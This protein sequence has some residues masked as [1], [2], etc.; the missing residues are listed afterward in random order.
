M[1]GSPPGPSGGVEHVSATLDQMPRSSLPTAWPAGTVLGDRYRLTSTL[2]IGRSATVYRAEEVDTGGPVTVQIFHEVGRG[3]RARIQSFRRPT[4]SRVPRPGLPGAFVA[5]YECDL[6]NEGQLFLVTEVVEGTS[7]A[8]LL[9]ETPPLAPARALELATRIGEALEATLNLGLL[10]FPLAPADIIV[11]DADRVRFLRSDVLVLRQLGLADQL[12]A[13]EG[14]ERD[15]RYVSPEEL[16]GLPATER[17]VVYRFGV[18]LYELLCGSVPFQGTT[19]GEVRERQLRSPLRQLSDRHPQVPAAVDG[20]VSRMLDLEPMRRP[21]DPTSILNELWDAACHLRSEPLA[22]PT[23]VA[24]PPAAAASPARPRR[25]WARSW[26]FAGVPIV[27]VGS[28][29]LAWF[30][31]Y[32][33][34]STSRPVPVPVPAAVHVTAPGGPVVA[35][36][37][38]IVPP[39]S[40]GISNGLQP[41]V[42]PTP[43]VSPPPPAPMADSVASPGRIGSTTP[44]ARR[45]TEPEGR[46]ASSARITSRGTASSGAPPPT[47]PPAEA[48]A[49]TRAAPA[50][51]EPEPT[52][53]STVPTSPF[54]PAPTVA[55]SPARPTQRTPDTPRAGDPTAI[56][57]WL[58][59]Q[60]PKPGE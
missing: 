46:P 36:P 60:G 32:P 11:A 51:A 18:L 13:A 19:P 50:R 14:A 23:D 24:S 3:D 28:A 25:S 27:V 29:A 42:L 43:P 39:T 49:P 41:P 44:I 55:V 22:A 15:P 34:L 16:A 20:L 52:R 10:E 31:L 26:A 47:A 38:A 9:R 30:H 59:G 45:V 21:T 54:Q 53:A 17:S 8:N 4:S 35:S 56:I 48:P 37:P 5:V 2:K 1:S 12:A 33:S 7:L 57:E 6:T 40:S 58:V